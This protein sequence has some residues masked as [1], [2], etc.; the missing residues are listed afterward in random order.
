MT[1][2]VQ[3]G[4]GIQAQD[5]NQLLRGSAFAVIDGCQ[6]TASS[7]SMAVD[8]ASGNVRFNGNT[9]SVSQQTGVPLDAADSTNPRKDI[10]FVD[11]TGTVQTMAGTPEA[12][13]PSGQTHRQTF[14]P[15]PPD[16]AN[17]DAVVLAEVWIPAG[18]ADVAD[19]DISDRRRMNSQSGGGGGSI[20]DSLSVTGWNQIDVSNHGFEGD[21]SGGDLAQF[22]ADNTSSGEKTVFFLPDGTYEWQRPVRFAGGTG[23]F[24]EPIPDG[25]AV[26]GKP[27]ATIYMNI[28]PTLSP[29]ERTMFDLGSYSAPISQAILENLHIDVGVE[30]EDRDAGIS[31]CSISDEARFKN[32]T[33]TRRH[34]L[35]PTNPSTDQN[36]DR[37]SLMVNCVEEDATATMH[38][39]ILANG[40]VHVSDNESVG[41]AIPLAAEPDHV[42]KNIWRECYVN[43]FTDNGFYL[44]DGPGSNHVIDC[45]ARDC[46][47]GN[48]RL[49]VNDYAENISVWMENPSYNST[50]IWLQEIRPDGY[51]PGDQ[52]D[53]PLV[54]DG[55][56]IYADSTNV[57]DIIRVGS[58]LPETVLKNG[59]VDN[60]ADDFILDIT[61]NTGKVSV[62]NMT[63]DDHATG[64]TRIAAFR[65]LADNIN[66]D[67]LTYRPH[68]PSGETG[69]SIFAIDGKRITIEN[70]DLHGT[71]IPVVETFAGA[72]FT[73]KDSK[74]PHDGSYT[75]PFII[76]NNDSNNVENIV[77]RHNDFSDYTGGLNIQLSN[78]NTH[79]FIGNHGL[80][81]RIGQ[82]EIRMDGVDGYFDGLLMGGPEADN[83]GYSHRNSTG[84]TVYCVDD[85]ADPGFTFRNHTADGNMFTVDNVTGDGW[86][87]GHVDVGSGGLILPD[88]AGG[89]LPSGTEAGR[90]VY[91]SSREQ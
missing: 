48:F 36:G 50:G 91:D 70:S 51:T 33:M 14:R 63:A 44:R 30:N 60:Y 59:Y 79:F 77:L 34:R 57:N 13:Q 22:V 37:Y 66:I 11:S 82:S 23:Q 16:T 47:A 88:I 75:D 15:S 20:Q 61:H 4:Y 80:T 76:R 55:F 18:A 27:R 38:R 35:D 81:D 56:E 72:D 31:R 73:I 90:M 25:V 49:G 12:A 3:D 40:D 52:P 39:V 68:P 2:L 5:I 17:T 69:R 86:F 87:R 45:G 53:R 1:E 78:I 74:F 58:D 32:I 64:Y 6:V 46:C 41:H 84:A 54:V 19:S 24:H 26:I 10:V 89:S 62:E 83:T 65:L 7:T 28:D 43:D 29:R 71:Y 85:S 9:V 21:R 67:N 8:V 42:G